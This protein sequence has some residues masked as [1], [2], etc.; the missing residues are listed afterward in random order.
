MK[1]AFNVG[2]FT[3]ALISDTPISGQV[4][5]ANSSAYESA[6][7][8]RP[9]TAYIAGQPAPDL[10]KVL[11]EL[12]PPVEAGRF[13]E[14]Q[15]HADDKFITESDDSDIRAVGAA[16]KVIQYTG[17]KVTDKVV[18]KG[19]TYRQDH[20]GLTRD[21]KG[22]LRPG[23]ENAIADN[24]RKRL[25]RADILRGFALLD[26][27]A[28][29]APVVWNAA[30]N[31]DGDLR[32]ACRLSLTGKGV[33]A[34]NLVIGDLAW[35]LRQDA[36]EAPGRTNDMANHAA[37]TEQMLASYLGLRKVRREDS[38]YQVKKG[39][40]KTDILGSIAYIYGAE[41]GLLL[42]DPSNIKRVWSATDSGQRFAVYINKKDKF[43]DITVEH[44]SKFIS[45][46]TA[47][48][49]KLTIAAA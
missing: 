41:E 48:I 28:T 39:G 36:Y 17:S 45:P 16:F 37:Y 1:N 46:I 44:Y 14:F 24:L 26:A 4:T 3:G 13:F 20:D 31:P 21:E 42:D 30:S 22:K 11:D 33:R 12:F 5:V 29:N 10:E 2:T 15:K 43:T 32:G 18:N 27:G 7:L 35:M 6:N 38:L 47:G 34:T 9:L 8:S 23:W 49:R 19:L 25:I 40:A